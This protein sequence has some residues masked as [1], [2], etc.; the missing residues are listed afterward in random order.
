MGDSR[1]ARR[2]GY[3]DYSIFPAKYPNQCSLWGKGLAV[4]IDVIGKPLG[5]RQWDIV[6]IACGVWYGHDDQTA[7]RRLI[8][9]I[10]GAAVP[11][12]LT[13][14]RGEYPQA[15]AR[16]CGGWSV[17][18]VDVGRISAVVR[19]EGVVGRAGPVERP[20]QLGCAAD[21]G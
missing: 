6:C 16:T 14:G 11:P 12:G 3:E 10:I 21:V 13:T 7:S 18:M 20:R 17:G 5:G 2:P 1:A 19:G 9:T 8:P 4:G 15:D